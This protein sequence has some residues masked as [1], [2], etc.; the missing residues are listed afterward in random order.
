VFDDGYLSSL[1]SARPAAAIRDRRYRLPLIDPDDFCV[2][3]V[4]LQSIRGTTIR[5]HE[6]SRRSFFTIA[7]AAALAGM[8]VGALPSDSARKAA[9]S[10]RA[11]NS[12]LLCRPQTAA[13]L[14][15]RAAKR[16]Q[17]RKEP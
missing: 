17:S 4:R 3:S 10:M 16:V 9:P 13:A 2:L 12:A 1:I 5:N 6:A 11:F 8:A 15:T 14:Q 7:F